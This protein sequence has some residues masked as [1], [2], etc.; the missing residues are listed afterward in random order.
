MVNRKLNLDTNVKLL[1]RLS[2]KDKDW[3]PNREL[4]SALKYRFIT[5][6]KHGVINGDYRHFDYVI[7]LPKLARCF[8][9]EVFF[10]IYNINSYGNRELVDTIWMYGWVEEK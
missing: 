1:C 6:W 2:V 3:E 10:N 4:I 5:W 9:G 8:G 7:D